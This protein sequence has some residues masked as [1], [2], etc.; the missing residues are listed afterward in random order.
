MS[1]IFV[2]SKK[3]GFGALLPPDMDNPAYWTASSRESLE[4]IA[5]Y[6]NRQEWTELANGANA[7]QRKYA[8]TSN[9]L[10]MGLLFGSC[11]V[12]FCPLMCYGLFI[13]VEKEMN[14]DIEKLLPVTQRLKERG[15]ALHFAP[16][17]GKFDMGGMTFSISAQ[18]PTLGPFSGAPVQVAK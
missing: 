9:S 14:A 10:V 17:R 11:G 16:K 4:K 8:A 13:D 3:L 12:C 2:P 18:T 7:A 6:V 15:I 1:R 5:Q